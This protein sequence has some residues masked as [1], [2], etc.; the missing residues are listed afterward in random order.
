MMRLSQ[1]GLSASAY[2]NQS[3][4]RLSSQSRKLSLPISLK[5]ARVLLLFAFSYSALAIGNG[6]PTLKVTKAK[7]SD[8]PQSGNAKKEEASS[9]RTKLKKPQWFTVIGKHLIT[10]VKECQLTS[11][12]QTIF[13]GVS[14]IKIKFVFSR[15]HLLI[16]TNANIDTSYKNTGV[17][18]NTA[19]RTRKF[20]LYDTNKKTNIVLANFTIK[21]V[22]HVINA[23]SISVTL[24][25]WPSWPKTKTHTVNVKLDGFTNAYRK[26]L[27]CKVAR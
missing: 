18:I 26:F 21:H 7:T 6:V 16:A 3:K 5:Y 15:L 1:T 11:S 8:R 9:A 10:G 27:K 14:K 22:M 2:K 24:G 19:E 12:T 23:K 13:D 20:S 25:F 4:Y 17:A